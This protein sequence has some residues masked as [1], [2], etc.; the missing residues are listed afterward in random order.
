MI[1]IIT[2]VITEEK[3][4]IDRKK[5]IVATHYFIKNAKL[6]LDNYQQS[7]A[8]NLPALDALNM[9]DSFFSNFKSFAL[10]LP[11]LAINNAVNS[12]IQSYFSTK[13]KQTEKKHKS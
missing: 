2:A 6:L 13:Q 10:F 9:F 3:H 4:N 11:V 5:Y 8:K 7:I 1:F 12:F